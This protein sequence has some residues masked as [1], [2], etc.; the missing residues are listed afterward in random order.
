HYGP[1]SAR[2]IGARAG[3]R[4]RMKRRFWLLMLGVALSSAAIASCTHTNA[5]VTLRGAGS[6]ERQALSEALQ[7]EP[8]TTI[9]TAHA[10]PG[11][12]PS[13]AEEQKAPEV[14]PARP[15]PDV[16]PPPLAPKPE[17]PP[18]VK[19]A[20]VDKLPPAPAATALPVREAPL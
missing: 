15:Q 1:A 8:A 9:Q 19:V 4:V 16:V 2:T 12:L 18:P 14:R 7:R 3:T 5:S 6:N 17:T 10:T 11:D 13:P 20:S